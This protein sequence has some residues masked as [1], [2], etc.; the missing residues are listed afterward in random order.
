MAIRPEG[1]EKDSR[2]LSSEISLGTSR[3]SP[4]RNIL[5]AAIKIIFRFDSDDFKFKISNLKFE[6]SKPASTYPGVT[7][8]LNSISS[9]SLMARIKRAARPASKRGSCRWIFASPFVSDLA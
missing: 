7:I 1:N 5:I 2:S 8:R 3:N 6:I 9:P 4:F